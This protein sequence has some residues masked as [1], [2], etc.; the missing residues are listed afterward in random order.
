MKA[1]GRIS[2]DRGNIIPIYEYKCQKCGF[3]IEIIQKI[4]EK[5]PNCDNK[6]VS[7]SIE[8]LC[9][10]KCEKLVSKSTFSLKGGGW[11]K[12]GY[13]KVNKEK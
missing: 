6:V 8:Q 2:I 7:G 3:R 9:G 12:D 4:D 10:G 13:T 5:T 11:Y 1:P